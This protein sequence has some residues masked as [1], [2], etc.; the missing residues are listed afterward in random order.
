MKKIIIGLTLL[1]SISTFAGDKNDLGEL[2]NLLVTI[3]DEKTNCHFQEIQ[4]KDLG[5]YAV[6]SFKTNQTKYVVDT[7][8][9]GNW[10]GIK[11]VESNI[12][13]QVYGFSKG[14]STPLS[15]NNQQVSLTLIDGKIE[16]VSLFQHIDTRKQKAYSVQNCTLNLE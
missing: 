13:K 2:A 6:L 1:S 4:F 9:F 8:S 16:G 15:E 10:S 3:Q 5:S 12:T 11:K 7:Q 14:V